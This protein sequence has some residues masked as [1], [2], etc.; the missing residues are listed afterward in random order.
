MAKLLSTES[1]GNAAARQRLTQLGAQFYPEHS[2]EGKQVYYAGRYN[3]WIVVTR[4]GRMVQ[5]ALYEGCP[6]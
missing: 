1:H 3:V 6:C 5:L 4:N 2:E